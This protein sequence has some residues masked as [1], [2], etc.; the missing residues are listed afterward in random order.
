MI[1][2]EKW[3]K[4]KKNNKRDTRQNLVRTQLG[5]IPGTCQALRCSPFTLKFS[6]RQLAI[7]LTTRLVQ[8][9]QELL[10]FS[11][12]T[13]P[14]FFRQA[15]YQAGLLAQEKFGQ[16]PTTQSALLVP[17]DAIKLL[18]QPK[19]LPFHSLTILGVVLNIHSSK[20]NASSKGQVISKAFLR[21][22]E[23]EMLAFQT[24]LLCDLL[25]VLFNFFL[26]FFNLLIL[27]EL[28]CQY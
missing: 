21:R 1:R 26:S 3:S 17:R 11:P 20:A 22:A 27:V 15:S 24:L 2:N 14:L 16:R 9:Q 7:Q 4:Q 5:A 10:C 8:H 19:V 23:H 6:S 12:F 28:Y 13:F 18:V 25:Q